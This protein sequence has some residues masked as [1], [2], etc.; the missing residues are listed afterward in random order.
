MLDP[1]TTISLDL[2]LEYITSNTYDYWHGMGPTNEWTL[3]VVP[4]MDM[5]TEHLGV[6]SEEMGHYFDEIRYRVHGESLRAKDIKC[7]Q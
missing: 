6:R 7:E 1:N 4:F 5:L 3:D 2:I